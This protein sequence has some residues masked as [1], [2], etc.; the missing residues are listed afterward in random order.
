ML[1][2]NGE[3]KSPY[4]SLVEL[5]LR[6]FEAHT[7]LTVKSVFKVKANLLPKQTLTEA[8]LEE[9]VHVDLHKTDKNYITLVYYVLNSDGNTIVFDD[10]KEV[11]LK[12]SP[13]KGNAVWF[14]S[15]MEHRA[16]PPQGHKRRVVLNIIMEV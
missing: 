3:I 12:A 4:Y 10:G 13:V 5:V 15:H 16:T 11:W 8:E 14:P 6:E 7:G 1:Y 9:T 2:V